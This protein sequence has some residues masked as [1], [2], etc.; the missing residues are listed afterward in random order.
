M[1]KANTH[2]MGDMVIWFLVLGSMRVHNNVRIK[3]HGCW[4]Q[5]F[6]MVL[7]LAMNF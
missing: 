6:C 5:G 4:N 2:V 3:V 7:G 1:G